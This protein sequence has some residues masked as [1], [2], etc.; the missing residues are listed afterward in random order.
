MTPINY[1]ETIRSSRFKYLIQTSTNGYSN[2]IVS[3]VFKD[4][5]QISSDTFTH[6]LDVSEDEIRKLTEKIHQRKK[7]ELF[8]VFS[9]LPK[10]QQGLILLCHDK[11]TSLVYFMVY[12][13]VRQYLM[14]NQK[15]GWFSAYY[16]PS[17]IFVLDKQHYSVGSIE[18]ACQ[19]IS[20]H[21]L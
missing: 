10:Y 19:N 4:G 17:V 14:T 5:N 8:L 1:N 15:L 9:L 13:H 3:A 6:D 21:Q 11:H 2:R 20:Y 18:V 12:Q 16:T 7:G